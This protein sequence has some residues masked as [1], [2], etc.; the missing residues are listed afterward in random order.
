MITIVNTN[1]SIN[2]NTG[3]LE[4]DESLAPKPPGPGNAGWDIRAPHDIVLMPG[5]RIFVDTGLVVQ[6]P[7][8]EVYCTAVPRSSTGTKWSLSMTNTFPVID[9]SYRGPSDNIK[10]MIE[11][12]PAS[13]VAWEVIKPAGTIIRDAIRAYLRHNLGISNPNTDYDAAA[14]HACYGIKDDLA[15]EMAETFSN[16]SVL[17]AFLEDH[18]ECHVLTATLS[19]ALHKEHLRAFYDHELE[20]A[21]PNFRDVYITNEDGPFQ[22]HKLVFTEDHALLMKQVHNANKPLVIKKGERFAQLIF[23]RFYGENHVN[24]RTGEPRESFDEALEDRGG[25]G[26]TGK[27]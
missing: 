7:L 6:G 25:F 17:G 5:T 4:Y 3:E 16:L 22:L 26:S 10:L 15:H 21:G 2:V 19:E 24:C 8:R 12:P 14:I 11:R 23:H 1:K 9:P 13:H 27:K 18:P 20:E